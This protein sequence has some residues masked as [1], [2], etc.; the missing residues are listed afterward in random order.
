VEALGD[1]RRL[2]LA[3]AAAAEI[4]FATA[5]AA[6]MLIVRAA[7]GEPTAEAIASLRECVERL[8]L[9]PPNG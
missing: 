2:V 1:A 9:S 5:Y 3:P 7:P 8:I 4:I 6:A